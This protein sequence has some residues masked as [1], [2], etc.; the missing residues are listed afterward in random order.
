MAAAGFTLAGAGHPIIPVM[1]GDAR[2]AVE[3]AERLLDEG[4]YVIA[5]SFPVVPQGKA[6]IRTQMSAAH[7]DDD[8]DHGDRR[9]R[10]GRHDDGAGLVKA[11]VKAR[12]E[13]GLW[14]EDV[15]EPTPGDGDVLIRVRKTSICG[16]DLHIH[17]WDAWA[18]A[19]IPVPMVVGHEFMGEIAAAR[20]RRRRPRGRP[21]GGRR[22]PRHVRSLPQLQR[23]AARV[24]PQPHQRRRHPARRVRRVRRASPPRTC[25]SCPPTS[26][27]TSPRCSIR[28]ATRPTPSL[29]FDVVGEDVL[30]TGAGPIGDPGDGDRAP[31]RRPQRRGHRRQPL[32]PRHGRQARRQPRRR[33]AHRAAR[34]R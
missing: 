14:L 8:I 29:R 22:G 21:A 12:P 30:I 4:I 11:L 20:R 6:R 3:M 26:T 19:T 10:P 34:A 24:L 5:F 7:T 33:R 28:S 18:Q 32:P 16:T 15:P 31:H 17:H 27:T 23:R 25:S 9:V 2:V 13:P 1:L